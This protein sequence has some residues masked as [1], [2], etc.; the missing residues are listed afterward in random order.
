M[1]GLYG[2][3]FSIDPHAKCVNVRAPIS[4]PHGCIDNVIHSAAG[5]RLREN[6]AKI[7]ALQS[8]EEATGAAKI[9]RACNLPSRFVLHTVGPIVCGELTATHRVELASAYMS[10]LDSPTFKTWF[11]G[12][13]ER[14]GL[15]FIYEAAFYDYPTPE[16]FL[17]AC[18]PCDPRS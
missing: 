2:H 8:F 11:P 9:T 5:P 4:P 13:H 18:A 12:Y 7:M 3:T 15:R 16:E 14:Y 1:L 17:A 10:C 6:C